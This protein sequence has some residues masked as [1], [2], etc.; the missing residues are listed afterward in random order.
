MIELKSVA[1]LPTRS[2]INRTPVKIFLRYCINRNFI[3]YVLN[4]Y[5]GVFEIYFCY[6]VRGLVLRLTDNFKYEWEKTL[7]NVKT[8]LISNLIYFL[9]VK[10]YFHW[11]L[12]IILRCEV[13]FRFLQLSTPFLITMNKNKRFKVSSV[14]L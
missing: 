1:R 13:C 2:Y 8:F 6:I 7:W 11:T 12:Y 5:Y 4:C 9:F 14:K 10:N 3:Q